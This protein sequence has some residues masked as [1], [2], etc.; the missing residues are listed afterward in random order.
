MPIKIKGRSL[1][2]ALDLYSAQWSASINPTEPPHAQHSN[3]EYIRTNGVLHPGKQE[4]ASWHTINTS[5][6]YLWR[7]T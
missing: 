4:I 6:F 5:K 1:V 3:K 7:Q 2:A